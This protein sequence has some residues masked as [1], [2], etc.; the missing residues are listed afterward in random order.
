MPAPGPLNIRERIELMNL[1]DAQKQTVVKWIQDGLKL[2]E[3]QTR[4]DTE[5][6]ARLT[7]MEVK[8]LLAELELRPKDQEPPKGTTNLPAPP[9]KDPGAAPLAGAREPDP[10][11]LT[12]PE[13]PNAGAPGS[14]PDGGVGG[15]VKVTIDTVMRPGSMV[16]GKVTFSDQKTAEWYLDQFG[17]L[18]LAPSEKGYRPSQMDVMAFQTEL[19]NQLAKMGF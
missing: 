10:I 16:S 18:G 17:R 14:A 3:I 7:Y 4:L 12:P 13:D 11:D 1:S 2:S 9:S 6:G 15:N 8:M 19:Q 5:M